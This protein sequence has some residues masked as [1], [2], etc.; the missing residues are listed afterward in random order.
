MSK[1]LSR[2]NCGRPLSSPSNKSGNSGKAA[3]YPHR[4][5][6]TCVATTAL[7]IPYVCHE[8]RRGGQRHETMPEPASA[9]CPSSSK[10]HLPKKTLKRFLMKQPCHPALNEETV[11]FWL[12]RQPEPSLASRAGSS[13]LVR[14]AWSYGSCPFTRYARSTSMARYRLPLR[15]SKAVSNLT[16]ML[17]TFPPRD[18]T[19]GPFRGF[20]HPASTRAKAN[21]LFSTTNTASSNWPQSAFEQRFV[22][23]GSCSCATATPPKPFL[24]A[25]P[26]P[27]SKPSLPIA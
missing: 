17:A 8:S 22:T 3:G 13:S 15:R 10:K 25:S 7:P 14:S 9:N 21:T 12:Y 6:T 26:V 1:F 20:R 19:S 23:S 16:S 11:K 5:V 4:C 27:P 2:P 24:S 18:A